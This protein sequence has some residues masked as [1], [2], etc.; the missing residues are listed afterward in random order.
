VRLVQ[1]APD[2]YAAK[3]NLP[4]ETVL[5]E[6]DST[7]MWSA[8][9][10]PGWDKAG[11]QAAHWLR[12]SGT[13]AGDSALIKETAVQAVVGPFHAGDSTKASIR[14]DQGRF[15]MRKAFALKGIPV[16][17]DAELPGGA[18]QYYL[19]GMPLDPKA[20]PE[21]VLNML[22][23]GDN[24]FAICCTRYIKCRVAVRIIPER[25]LPKGE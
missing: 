25:L 5:L 9:D 10:H 16:S 11:F 3:L 8:L 17:A 13:F 15:F 1:Y 18:C 20:K 12:F 23:R 19:N 4:L 24:V 2:A 7:W 21:A 22:Y 14:P 6:P